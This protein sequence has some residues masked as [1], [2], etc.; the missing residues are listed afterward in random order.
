[1]PSS[2]HSRVPVL[3]AVCQVHT[4]ARELG[5]IC[6]SSCGSRG[7]GSISMTPQHVTSSVPSGCVQCHLW[8]A[9]SLQEHTSLLTAFY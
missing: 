3:G 8:G 2:N 5:A 1:M 7:F 4:Q 6:H 9:W